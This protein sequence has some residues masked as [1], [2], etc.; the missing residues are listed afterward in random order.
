MFRFGLDMKM[1]L[2]FSLGVSLR[3]WADKGLLQ[4]EKLLYERLLSEKILEKIYWLTYGDDEAVA[5]HL[6]ESGD[7]DRR[8][9]VVS[10]PKWL[11]F[12]IIGNFIYSLLAP[13]LRSR[14]IRDADVYK[15]NQIRGAWTA[16]IAKWIWRKPVVARCGF[17]W[18]KYAQKRN[19]RTK[20][21]W[22]AG[23]IERC[24]F[25]CADA[26]CVASPGD[27]EYIRERYHLSSGKVRVVPNFVDTSIFSPCQ[28]LMS[29]MKRFVYVG[30]LTETKN[31][32]SLICAFQGLQTGLDVYGDG[33]LEEPLRDAV[34][35]SGVD[36]RFCGRVTNDCLPDILN[37]YQFFVLPSLYE[38]TPKALLEAMACGLVC[39]GTPVEGIRDIIIHG[40]NGYLSAGINGDELRKI[41]NDVVDNPEND[42]V[43]QDARRTVEE[44]FSL[45][46]ILAKEKQIYQAV[47]QG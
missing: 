27:A 19:D 37:E 28:Q 25:R 17:L 14:E 21:D 13:I 31:L 18:S 9:V 11:N 3:E 32:F 15:T 24:V 33:L 36:V 29:R 44:G 16:V 40:Q 35:K 45:E 5:R 22:A 43:S 39:V 10:I 12:G 6:Y 30:R 20:L 4:R 7:L 46:K 42:R 26:C 41:I 1:M 23:W 38:G 47:C 8:I 34:K 2:F